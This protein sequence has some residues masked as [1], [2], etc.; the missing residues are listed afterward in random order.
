MKSAPTIRNISS[1]RH[2]VS[3]LKD[4]KIWRPLANNGVAIYSHELV[5]MAALA[6]YVDWDGEDM[7]VPGS[8]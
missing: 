8:I 4:E 2:V 7:R 5:L 6:Q 3:C 1:T